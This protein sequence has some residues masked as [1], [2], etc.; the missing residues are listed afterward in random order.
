MAGFSSSA[1]GHW[2][3]LWPPV[4][5]VFGPVQATHSPLVQMLL[6]QSLFAAQNVVPV[7]NP[8]QRLAPVEKL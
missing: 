2:Q 7:L 6:G 1:N 8:T 4:I 3:Q 5:T